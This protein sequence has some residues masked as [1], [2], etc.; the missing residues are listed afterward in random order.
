M[1]GKV[2]IKFNQKMNTSLNTS[3]IN[4]TNTLI[5]VQ[6]Q[7]KRDQEIEFNKSNLDLT[8]FVESFHNDVMKINLKFSNPLEISPN[9][10]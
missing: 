2:V 10:Q 4:Q 1:H 3:S 6:P 9:I 5:Y 8:W 7:D